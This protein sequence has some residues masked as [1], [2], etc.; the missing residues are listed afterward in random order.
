M[1]GVL[2]QDDPPRRAIASLR[3]GR[4]PDVAIQQG[5]EGCAWPTVVLDCFVVTLLAMTEVV[6]RL[7]LRVLAARAPE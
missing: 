1:T 2:A 6:V 3:G 4:E 7:N 5:D